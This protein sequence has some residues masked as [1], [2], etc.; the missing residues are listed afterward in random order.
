MTKPRIIAIDGP[1]ASGKSTIGEL[2]A[3]RCG[4]LYFDTGVMYRAATWAA[5]SRGLDIGDEAAVTA[6]AQRLHLE[7]LPSTVA[8]GRQNTILCDA[9]DITWAIR[10][11]AVDQGVSPVSAYQGVRQAMVEQQRRIARQGPVVMAGRDIGTVV[12]PEADLKIYLDATPEVRAQRRHQEILARGEP[13]DYAQVLAAMLRRD[14]IDST[15]AISPLKPAA[16]AIIVDSTEMT[17]QQVLECVL[18]LVGDCPST[19]EE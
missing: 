8:D 13:S 19:A 5:L 12:L 15:R 3:K 14:Q 4:Y 11:P 2:L 18:R 6:L 9:E 10:T 17:V 16:D 7:V 1:A